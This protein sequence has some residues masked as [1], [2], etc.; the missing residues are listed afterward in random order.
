MSLRYATLD[1]D[2]FWQ[3]VACARV[4]TKARITGVVSGRETGRRL[5]PVILAPQYGR[6]L[7]TQDRSLRLAGGKSILGHGQVT[8]EVVLVGDRV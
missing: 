5:P 7:S 6:R 4:Q 1:T 8:S 2:T 3:V